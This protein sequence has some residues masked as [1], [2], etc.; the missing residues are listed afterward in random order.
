MNTARRQWRELRQQMTPIMWV[1]FAVI[2]VVVACAGG[3][4]A[5]TIVAGVLE[6]VI[7]VARWIIGM[8]T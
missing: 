7:S 4:L 3:V 1:R 5:L 8:L 6:A 2:A